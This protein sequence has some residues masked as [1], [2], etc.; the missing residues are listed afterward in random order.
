MSTTKIIRLT[1]KAFCCL[2]FVMSASHVFALDLQKQI[3]DLRT[4]YETTPNGVENRIVF[5]WKMNAHNAYKAWQKAYRIMLAESRQQ[6]DAGKLLY[7]SKKQMGKLSVCIDYDG[8]ELKP[9]MRYYWKVQVWDEKGKVYESL[10]SWF[11]TALGRAGW[12]GAQWI[13]S[14]KEILSPYFMNF[15][16]DMDMQI[17]KSGRQ[18]TFLFGYQNEENYCGMTFKLRDINDT[19]FTDK[20]PKISILQKPEL[21]FFHYCNATYKEDRTIDLSEEIASSDLNEKHHFQLTNFPNGS[22]LY[23][24][25]LTLDGK[26]IKLSD[27]EDILH[28]AEKVWYKFHRMYDIG[29]VHKEGEKSSISNFKIHDKLSNTLL[30]QNDSVYITDNGTNGNETW[31]AGAGVSAPQFRKTFVVSKAVK[32]ARLYATSRGVYEMFINGQPVS[33]DFLN[34]G[35]TDYRKRIMYNTYDVTDL[36][37]GGRNAIGAILG[38]GWWQGR[39]FENFIWYTPYGYSL[40]LLSKLLI[41]YEDGTVDT[42][43]SDGSWLCTNNG[44]VTRND[45]YDGQTYDARLEIPD[46]I[47]ADCDESHWQKVKTVE[48]PASDI[49]ISPYIGQPIRMDVIMNAKAV[50]EPIE[51]K[52]I[53]DMGQN[54][55]GVPQIKLFGKAGQKITFRYG[56]MKY[57]D[58]IPTD[59]VKPYTIDDY[60]R[61]KG[62]LYTENYRGAASVDNYIC[63]G[64]A[65]GE[66]FEPHLTC[67]GFRYIEISG[68]DNAPALSDVRVVV[69]NSL[70]DEQTCTFNTSDDLINQLFHNIQWGEKSNF[71]TVPTDCPQRDERAGWCGDAQIFCRTAT[72]NRNVDPFY[73]RW[74]T[75]MRDDQLDDGNYRDVV[76]ETS[77]GGHFGW[78]DAGVIVPWQVYQQYGDKSVLKSSYESMTKYIDYIEKNGKDL[79]QP[80]GGYGD[81]VAVVGTQSD[82]T[83]TCYAA[84][85]VQIM[86]QVAK[87]LGK[88]ADEQR[89]T[90]LFQ[91]MKNA[92]NKR[93]VSADGHVVTPVGSPLSVSPYGEGSKETA[94][95][96]TPIK[97][98]TAYVVPL[99]MNMIN[100][101]VKLKAASYLADLV[102]ENGFKL[103]TGFIGTPYLNIVLSDN[104]YDDM[105]YRLIQQQEFPSWLYPILQGATTMWER[106]NSYTIK[107]GFGPVGMN[108]FNHYAYGAVEDWL[109]AYSAGI[110]RDETQPGYRHFFLQ[111]RV[112]GKFS[113]VETT[114]KSM[115]GLIESKWT[116][117]NAAEAVNSSAANYG[118][119][120]EATIPANTKA[121]LSLPVSKDDMKVLKGKKGVRK[122]RKMDNG[123]QV[124]L[125]SGSYKFKIK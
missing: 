53:Y 116:S 14:E 10:P 85:D 122:I 16:V 105:A 52:F 40:S 71:L 15:V 58:Q 22:N 66:I 56:E 55:V 18:A 72:Y 95:E 91:N 93:F 97:T 70:Q 57:P 62:Q 106:W 35:W 89:F 41:E 67:H 2:L 4:N 78:A 101:S 111:P 33:S 98:Q 100:E 9:C 20:T 79:I 102:K 123:I 109:I 37:R 76:P 94:K 65:E 19:V 13:G 36:L 80:F 46:W 39:R 5:G 42:V 17:Q 88:K 30:Y 118:Y 51:G 7:D 8:P 69:I 26:K 27:K 21:V 74:L 99:Y 108:S 103:N 125:S 64:D 110:Q 31:Q 48:A 47:D 120:Y 92:F 32:Q 107:N 84:Y 68:L 43:V 112:G 3:V 45:L 83:N 115:Y 77:F 60:K 34:P 24:L 54:M 11:E 124:E 87:A 96:P 121:T 63:K 82:L 44:P 59:P 75:S 12:S 113:F 73:H 61:L 86:I 119:T 81:W 117:D 49:I 38:N 29:V 6:L 1:L 25:S 28:I 104:G 23:E 114:F 90:T 50:D